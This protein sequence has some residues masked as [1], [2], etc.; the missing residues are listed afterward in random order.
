ME[1]RLK[2]EI[3]AALVAGGFGAMQ[4]DRASSYR[5]EKAGVISSGRWSQIMSGQHSPTIDT[6]SRVLDAVGCELCVR[7]KE[8]V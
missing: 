5:L 1:D 6:L 4:G 7:K 8:D 3:N 2:S